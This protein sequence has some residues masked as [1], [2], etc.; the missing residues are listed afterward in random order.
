MGGAMEGEGRVEKGIGDRPVGVFR[1]MPRLFR[2]PRV[3]VSLPTLPLPAILLGLAACGGSSPSVSTGGHGGH[4]GQ[5]MV[6]Q[7][8]SGDTRG[9]NDDYAPS[10]GTPTGAGDDHW[11]FV[12][13]AAGTYRFHVAADFDSVVALRIAAD[14]VGCN[15]D[16]ESKRESVLVAGLTEG[17]IYDVVVDGFQA[18]AG[19][20]LLTVTQDSSAPPPA[21][22]PEG[23][24]GVLTLGEPVSGATPGGSDH[25]TPSCGAQAGSPD[26]VWHF[27]A[28]EAGSYQFD[29]AS[30]YDA[31]LA[32]VDESGRELACNDDL[33]ST[34]ASRIVIDLAAGTYG[35]VVDGY[36]GATGGYQLTASRAGSPSPIASQTPGGG[37]INVG[38]TVTGNTSGHAD[39]FTPSC[40]SR[41]GSGDEVWTLQPPASGGIYRIHVSAQYDATVAVLDD[42]GVEIVCNDDEGD[43]TESEVVVGLAAG[44]TYRVVVDGFSGATGS[45]RLSVQPEAAAAPSPQA[46]SQPPTPSAG[47]LILRRTVS[48]STAGGTNQFEPS[49]GARAGTPD[50]V[51]EFTTGATRRAHRFDVQSQY[52]AVLAIYD[53]S[54]N[55]EVDCND[56]YQ[57]TSQSRI[58]ARL[59]P[60]T[61]YFI[62]VDGYRGASGAYTLRATIPPKPGR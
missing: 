35:I 20:Y 56:D 43:R 45:Y 5:V 4:A 9:A 49:C 38:Q 55:T 40:G 16:G 22:V 24:Q 44:R 31:T 36:R 58:E 13:P 19:T 57:N 37:N 33:D 50:D 7:T 17:A 28:T 59:Q 12:A 53:P 48:D 30:Q 10:C 11:K 15:D 21:A 1:R 47:T 34:S 8:V 54:T 2:L 3:T 42:Q 26:Q 6:G 18:S 29:T 32:I 61:R 51:W 60:R 62:V 23:R 14:E 27:V 25:H 46:P 39:G 52:D 41:A